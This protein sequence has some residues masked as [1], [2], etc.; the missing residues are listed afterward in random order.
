MKANRVFNYVLIL[1]ALN[2]LWSCKNQDNRIFYDSKYINEIKKA[3]DDIFVFLDVNSIPG[4]SL[5]ISKDGKLIYSEG[6]G[7]A[8]KD[9]DVPVN[10]NTKFRVGS[11]STLF[12]SVAYLE[13]VKEGILN[14]DSAIQ[15]YI[16]NYPKKEYKITLNNLVNQ[17]SGIRN[18]KNDEDRQNKFEMTLQS[19]LDLF[20][21]DELLFKP[22]T[23]QFISVFNYDLL[24]AVMEKA[25]GKQFNKILH[26]YV[27]D[28]LHLKNTVIDNPFVTIKNRTN[29]YDFN[30]I[31]LPIN[32]TF[33][34]LISFAPSEGILSNS[35]DLV[36]LGNAFLYSDYI[37]RGMRTN[38]FT[39]DTLETGKIQNFSYGWFINQDQYGR[40]YYARAGNVLGGG[41]VLLI[42]PD[43][44]L[45]LACAVNAT[46]DPNNIPLYTI[47]QYF[48]NEIQKDK[49]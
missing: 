27:T 30:V 48:L 2:S 39:P 12:T 28:T 25:T 13:L 3:R 42:Y 16:P 15:T 22:G 4:C 29:F 40:K 36:N 32:A 19:G 10:T 24:G 31:A 5:A 9:L 21:N 43:E 8:S 44:G 17:T 33:V 20:K 46:I 47:A 26:E 35:E 45:V 38:I 34:D 7:L 1:A 41:S 37:A 6:F 23:Y 49:K 11:V 18:L 14:P